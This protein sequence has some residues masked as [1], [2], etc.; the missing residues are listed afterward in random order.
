MVWCGVVWC[1]TVWCGVVGV[2][3]SA[4]CAVL[5]IPFDFNLHLARH[6]F[7][8]CVRLQ[9]Y[10]ARKPDP[11]PCPPN[12]MW[13]LENTNPRRGGVVKFRVPYRLRHVASSAYLTVVD[14]VQLTMSTRDECAKSKATLFLLCPLDSDDVALT[15]S[16]PMR[17]KHEASGTQGRQWSCDSYVPVDSTSHSPACIFPHTTCASVSGGWV[18]GWGGGERGRVRADNTAAEVCGFEGGRQ[19]LWVDR[20][21]DARPMSHGH[22][23]GRHKTKPMAR[24]HG[25][26]CGGIQGLVQA[27]NITFLRCPSITNQ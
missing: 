26:G 27:G 13:I 5:C 2:L 23:S 1:G 14:G 8:P 20:E 10:M 3:C 6:V 15:P 16:T 7:A 18:G 9:V 21:R 25:P 17:L 19:C 11:N 4:W 22:V 24:Y 12:L